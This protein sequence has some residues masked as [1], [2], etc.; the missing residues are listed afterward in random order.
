[1]SDGNFR[2]AWIDALIASDVSISAMALGHAM[3]WRAG[4]RTQ[5]LRKSN[6][7]LMRETHI[8]TVD[9]LNRAK[10]QLVDAGLI[11]IK[12][13][14]HTAEWNTYELVLPTEMPEQ[15]AHP[16]AATSAVSGYPKI[17]NPPPENLRTLPPKNREPLS[18]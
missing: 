15:T 13:G 9:T 7:D 10:K 3:C 16:A 12:L 11:H 2:A 4:P 14:R 8:G 18:Y 17:G 6:K 5:P 1:M